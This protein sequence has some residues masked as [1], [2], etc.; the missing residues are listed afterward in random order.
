MLNNNI[1]TIVREDTD[2][3]KLFNSKFNKIIYNNDS[4][5]V[6]FN[7][8][9]ICFLNN[10]NW[11]KRNIGYNFN[12]IDGC[13]LND[14]LLLICIYENNVH[15]LQSDITDNY[16]KFNILFETP[17]IQNVSI[18]SNKKMCV[19]II[20]SSYYIINSDNFTI[21]NKYSMNSYNKVI[22]FNN[23]L[24]FISINDKIISF[25]KNDVKIG[26]FT[27]LEQL[28]NIY[29]N[30]LNQVFIADS[31]NIYNTLD[32][33]SFSTILN[34]SFSINDV[35]IT[36]DILISI[37]DYQYC[38]SSV[39]GSNK[40]TL[41]TKSNDIEKYSIAYNNLIIY[42]VY[43]EKYTTKIKILN[44]DGTLVQ[45]K[46][47][48][49]FNEDIVTVD[50]HNKSSYLFYYSKNIFAE[51]KNGS[52]YKFEI[53]D[54]I[55]IS[56]DKI[57]LIYFLN[58]IYLIGVS[59]SKLR[60]IK[61]NEDYTYN[62]D[63]TINNDLINLSNI[64]FID[65]IILNDKIT[66]VLSNSSITT[67]FTTTDFIT[68][69]YNQ[70]KISCN[71]TILF[72]GVI[73]LIYENT[74]NEIMLFNTN[75]FSSICYHFKAV[76]YVKTKCNDDTIVTM[77]DNATYIVD[78][79]LTAKKLDFVITDIA[80]G[81]TI[82]CIIDGILYKTDKAISTLEKIDTGNKTISKIEYINQY[83]IL[84]YVENKISFYITSK[85]LKFNDL[86]EYKT[87]IYK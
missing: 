57:K 64:S 56:F 4:A 46:N 18:H 85:Q 17:Y 9:N 49:L 45:I 34:L 86:Y 3:I 76:N 10:D 1:K 52:F 7:N 2:Y 78:S 40:L 61:L 63:I 60:I 26:S 20:D 21:S 51:F 31:K 44:K 36:D 54:K 75:D 67:F 72:N 16:L 15:I 6:L 23:E 69:S 73:Y 28:V 84:I 82:L 83:Y 47:K 62:E 55:K 77:C 14:K 19:V 38:V 80:F 59:N 30:E 50:N 27:I 5:I 11:E 13:F 41:N 65:C 71:D 37:G 79:N 53:L 42:F 39:D 33:I 24:I 74:D 25:F 32:M 68:I 29:V 43:Y 12:I 87:I 22:L 81:E 70:R 35:L 8:G 58:N 66:C 48:I